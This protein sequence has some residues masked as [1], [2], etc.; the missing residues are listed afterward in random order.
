METKV[1]MAG[2]ASADEEVLGPGNGSGC[3]AGHES[4]SPLFDSQH[5]R[6]I[7]ALWSMLV[8]LVLGGRDRRSP[9]L[10]GQSF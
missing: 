4:P 3:S 7:Q 10:A 6:D 9:G 5:P 2:Y 8:I 1:I